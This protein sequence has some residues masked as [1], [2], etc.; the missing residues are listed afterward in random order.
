MAKINCHKDSL[1]GYV[2]HDGKT[3][4]V[5]LKLPHSV[6]LRKVTQRDRSPQAVGPELLS[7]WFGR[8][9]PIAL[10]PRFVWNI[11]PHFK[12]NNNKKPREPTVL[13]PARPKF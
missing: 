10:T 9:P 11:L 8:Y 3:V 12:G 1:F 2:G 5:H 4:L 6:S 13:C 7:H